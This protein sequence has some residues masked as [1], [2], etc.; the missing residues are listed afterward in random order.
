MKYGIKIHDQKEGETHVRFC[1]LVKVSFLLQV[2]KFYEKC[3]DF[4]V[5]NAP[6]NRLAGRGSVSSR[7]SEFFLNIHPA[8]Y[9]MEGNVIF[10][11]KCN[12]PDHAADNTFQSSR[13]HAAL[14]AR[15]LQTSGT[16]QFV[17]F[18]S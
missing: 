4:S 1:L 3:H 18:L 13:L 2:Q 5:G 15:P 7:A 11:R 9:I 12:D 6:S 14:P 17:F 10:P 16:L 8:S